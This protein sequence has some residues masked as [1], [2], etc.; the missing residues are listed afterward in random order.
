MLKLVLF[1][2]L[3]ALVAAK[4]TKFSEIAFINE[5]LIAHNIYRR[6]HGAEPLELSDELS[7][8]ALDRA[9]ELAAAGEI[10]VKLTKWGEEPL[11]E[12]V[13]SVKGFKVYSG[14]SA[15]Q[16]WYGGLTKY[17]EF[18]EQS[19]G[20]ASFTQLIWA[21]TRKVG[22]GI[23]KDEDGVFYFVAEYWPRGNIRGA[24]SD[25]VK[26][27]VVELECTPSENN[28]KLLEDSD[29]SALTSFLFKFKNGDGKKHD[30]VESVTRKPK[31]NKI[32][33][34]KEVAKED[35]EDED[36]PKNKKESEDEDKPKDKKETEEDNTE[37]K[38]NK[39]EEDSDE[40]KPKTKKQDI[41]DKES[42]DEKPVEKP[43]E[44]KI[45]K[46]ADKKTAKKM[47]KKAQIKRNKDENS[48]TDDNFSIKREAKEKKV[49]K[50]TVKKIVK[51]APVEDI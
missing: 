49:V 21:E 23:A 34:K 22:F 7:K 5:A 2:A 35:I 44:K 18:G 26:Q 3:A 1:L 29:D 9:K 17:D 13:G 25:N 42:D 14:F 47:V 40:E 24:Y 16:Q 46:K 51:K 12:T 39:K 43:V 41:D 8:I 11:G 33:K 10:S 50:K 28:K 15:T 4:T 20:S 19:K 37:K 6:I 27:L 45:V 38:V 31:V 36:K 30:I 48:E 32:V